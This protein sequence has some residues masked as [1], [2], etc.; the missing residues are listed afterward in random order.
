[1]LI[2]QD[3]RWFLYLF[4]G[5]FIILGSYVSIGSF[6]VLKKS[7]IFDKLTGKLYVKSQKLFKQVTTE[8]ERMLDEIKEALVV[9]KTDEEGIKTYA[10][11]VRLRASQE[12]TMLKSDFSSNSYEIAQSIN[13]FLGRK[14]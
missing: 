1:M 11:K 12:I 7:Y 9:E 2:E 5:S 3:D 8:E 13:Q 4:G 14:S 6:P 10:T